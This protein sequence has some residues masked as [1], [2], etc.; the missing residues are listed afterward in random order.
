MTTHS[1]LAVIARHPVLL[2]LP[3]SR[4]APLLR[5]SAVVTYR[6]G[7]SVWHLGH[8]ADDFAFVLEGTVGRF[9][10]GLSPR[11][12]FASIDGAGS[13][14]DLS[15][16]VRR[17]RRTQSAVAFAARTTVAKIP[18]RPFLEAL[19]DSPDSMRAL[20]EL[21]AEESDAALRRLALSASLASTRLAHL[22]LSVAP[23]DA[24]GR[25]AVSLRLTRE[26][27]AQFIGSTPETVT[28]TLTAWSAEGLVEK[29]ARA[30][31]LRDIAR[32]EALARPS[33]DET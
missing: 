29:R 9:L 16:S 11:P 17:A 25:R 5:S 31:V 27:M 15:A 6:R 3:E 10:S 18:Q 32:L 2:P 1:A 13:F 33:F 19:S 14:S 23:P 30:L 4:L 24:A 8:P 21:A 26:H 28:R 12:L 20:L 7:D 22:L